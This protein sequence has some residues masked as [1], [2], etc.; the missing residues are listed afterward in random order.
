MLVQDWQQ[1]K[2]VMDV[3][4]NRLISVSDR[5]MQT[6]IASAAA[7]MSSCCTCYNAC[8]QAAGPED[9]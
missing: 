4:I 9:M 1:S 7:R 3:A 6:E 5:C 8:R 2:A